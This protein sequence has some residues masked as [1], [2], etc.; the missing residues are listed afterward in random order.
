MFRHLFALAVLCAAPALWAN[1]N[2]ASLLVAKHSA[3]FVA[4]AVTTA[5]ARPVVPA[6]KLK[7]SSVTAPAVLTSSFPF[8]VEIST[9]AADSEFLMSYG[10]VRRVSFTPGDYPVRHS[11]LYYVPKSAQGKKNLKALVIMHG[12]GEHTRTEDTAASVT[13]IYLSYFLRMTDF[14]ERNSL[15]LMAP[16]SPEGW[17]VNTQ[18]MREEALE[19]ML[20]ELPVNPEKVYLFGHSM[21]GMGMTRD[22]WDEADRYA[23]FIINSAAMPDYS[24][25]S[26]QLYAY[27]NAPIVHL[28]G[29]HDHF[30]EFVPN[31]KKERDA[32]SALALSEGVPLLYRATFYDGNHQ[33]DKDLLFSNLNAMFRK[34]RNIPQRK[35]FSVL[36]YRYPDKNTIGHAYEGTFWLQARDFAKAPAQSFRLLAKAE[37][38]AMNNIT[39]TISNYARQF[40]TLRIYLSKRMVATYMPVRVMV[41][42]VVFSRSAVMGPVVYH[43]TRFDGYVDVPLA[44]L[45]LTSLPRAF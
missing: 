33:I 19:K 14:A 21:G 38:N 18:M 15:V 34:S 17:N 29:L 42:G 2:Q 1:T 44:S 41:N 11:V 12:G 23:G 5:V 28:Q 9:L 35:I 37:I 36:G 27:L 16:V 4:P 39:V 45:S 32:I 3:G 30:K 20:A 13:M 8:S 31:T 7:A 24:R 25:N 10:I 22:I 40:G 6:A 43:H 26:F